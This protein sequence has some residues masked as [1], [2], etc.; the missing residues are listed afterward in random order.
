MEQQS[1]DAMSSSLKIA[2]RMQVSADIMD[3]TSDALGTSFSHIHT[4]V[5]FYACTSI[6]DAKVVDI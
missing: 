5:I 3:S 1:I 4:S 6:R 2:V